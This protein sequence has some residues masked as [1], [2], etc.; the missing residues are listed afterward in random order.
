MWILDMRA[1]GLNFQLPTIWSLSS[2]Q[3]FGSHQ[4]N[5]LHLTLGNIPM[6]AMSQ[7]VHHSH[8]NSYPSKITQNLKIFLLIHKGTSYLHCQACFK[9]RI[10]EHSPDEE[11][12]GQRKDLSSWS[13]DAEI[14]GA[15]YKFSMEM[16]T[17]EKEI[18]RKN[19]DP[20]L[21]N[22]CGGHFNIWA[23]HTKFRTWGYW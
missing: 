1:G 9:Q 15:F 19:A 20:N 11:Y 7:A 21:R 13:G 12:I 4:H 2:Q 17:I 3:L 10:S 6:V 22:R 23:A 5:I 14:I 16:R 8:A 18:E